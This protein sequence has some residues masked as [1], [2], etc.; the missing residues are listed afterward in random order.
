ME[1]IKS[2]IK[3]HNDIKNAT[4]RALHIYGNLPFSFLNELFNLKGNFVQK[5][6][7]ELEHDGA[8]KIHKDLVY[9]DGCEFQEIIEG[10]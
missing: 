9:L 10:L 1:L 5:M 8:V 2:Q 6:C 3:Y 4:V 7:I